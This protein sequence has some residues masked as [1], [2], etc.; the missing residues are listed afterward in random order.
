MSSEKSKWWK[1]PPYSNVVGGLI[2]AAILGLIK[3]FYDWYTKTEILSTFNEWKSFIVESLLSLVNYPIKL[4]WIFT[5]I[6]TISIL[7]FIIRLLFGDR[8]Q[9]SDDKTPII[10]VDNYYQ[11]Q[12]KSA[13]NRKLEYKAA[14]FGDYIWRWEWILNDLIQDYE[15]K[16]IV[17]CCPKLECENEIMDLNLSEL[18]YTC[19]KCRKTYIINVSSTQVR[20]MVEV[21]GEKRLSPYYE[22]LKKMQSR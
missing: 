5:F 2:L 9:K 15:V 22:T 10:H 16:K 21:E 20:K 14:K 12:T 4:W 13:L 1:T 11:L 18:A 19:P 3:V 7:V 8:D 6:F 17:P